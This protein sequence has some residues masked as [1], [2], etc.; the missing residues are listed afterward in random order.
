VAEPDEMHAPSAVDG[1][2]RAMRSGQPVEDPQGTGGRPPLDPAHSAI[3]MPATS[4][5][6]RRADRAASPSS[7]ADEEA[8]VRNFTRSADKAKKT[9]GATLADVGRELVSM[10][11]AKLTVVPVL[12]GLEDGDT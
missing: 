1:C 5:S 9:A 2:S 4:A 12:S 6:G 8:R 3:R 10:D 11:S 7:T